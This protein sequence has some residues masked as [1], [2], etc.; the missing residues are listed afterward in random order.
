MDT[1]GSNVKKKSEQSGHG[2]QE[3]ASFCPLFRRDTDPH[4]KKTKKPSQ[5]TNFGVATGFFVSI[6]PFDMYP[7]DI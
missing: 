3:L 1:S 2:S 4:P 7:E 5:F 6:P